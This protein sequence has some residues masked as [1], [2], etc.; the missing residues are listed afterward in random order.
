VNF[1]V[2]QTRLSE[3]Q[4]AQTAASLEVDA[5]SQDGKSLD[6]GKLTIIDN[7]VNT[8]AGTV[9]MQATFANADESLWP[10]EFV[11]VHLVESM[12]KNASW[13]C[14]RRLS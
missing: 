2:P 5:F 1:N 7:Q 10:G 13:L 14:R 12:R 8:S 9:T 11:R 3:I 6:K 4:R